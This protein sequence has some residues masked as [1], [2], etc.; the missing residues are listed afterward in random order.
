METVDIS[1]LNNSNVLDEKI[2]MHSTVLTRQLKG[3]GSSAPAIGLIDKCKKA[4]CSRRRKLQVAGKQ[5]N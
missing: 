3:E 4:K 2:M 1:E 5:K